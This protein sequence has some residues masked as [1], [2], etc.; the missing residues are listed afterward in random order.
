[1][2]QQ[3]L[4]QPILV[5][6][7][8]AI[9][10]LFLWSRPVWQRR[11][12]I[13]G[14][15]LALVMAA[16]LFR[17]VWQGG[18]I[19]LQAGNWPAP[20]GIT[21]VADTLSATLVLLASLVGLAV[22]VYSGTAIVER[23]VNFGYFAI[24]HFLMMGLNGAFLTG[25]IF[26]LY[27]WFEVIIISSFVLLTIGGEKMQIEG[28]VKY[29]TL[30]V[31]ASVIF[32]TAIAVLYGLT[33]TLNMADLSLRIAT[34][35]NRGL[36]N[37]SALIFLT[38]FGIKAAIF[39]LYFWLPSSYHT[40]PV[41]VSALFAGLLTKLGVYAMLRV[42][43]L[44]FD[45]DAFMQNLIL[46][47][48]V[49][50]MVSGA[51]G[52]LKQDNIKKTFSWLIICHI[53]FMVAGLGMGSEQALEGAVFYMVH[54]IA[55]KANLFLMAGLLY[56]IGA[57]FSM[58]ESGGLMQWFPGLSL[59][60]AIPLFSLA[61]IPP[62]SGFWPKVSLISAGLAQGQYLV[63]GTIL[64]ASLITLVVIAR[65]WAEVFWKPG[66]ELARRPDFMYYDRM[67]RRE[68]LALILPIVLLALLSLYIGLGAGNMQALA[69]RIAGELTDPSAYIRAVL[70]NH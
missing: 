24:F 31:V 48:A 51:L 15:L 17:R 67:S 28:A 21:L 22:A 61:G 36:V 55:V 45:V 37:V 5:H 29:F 18:I 66:R 64:L 12:S 13:L 27:V 43:T 6:L 11:V 53:G 59:L 35:E 4:I 39:P 63:V 56:R 65:L 20:Y 30:N 3:L 46:T 68:K 40:P 33:G 42:F 25:D 70:P 62:L 19:T 34:L 47:L 60:L 23:R 26:N 8:L 14:S 10:L 16:G 38:G 7:A 69:S 41:A 2:T 44:M 9:T 50:S 32:L 1:M 54:D 57:T 58:K 52:A 49:L